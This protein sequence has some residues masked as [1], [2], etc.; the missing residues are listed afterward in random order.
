LKY[1]HNL[2]PLKAELNPACH[3]L[4]LLG[5]HNILHISRIRVNMEF[6]ICGDYNINFLKNSIFKQQI[7]IFF[8]TYNLFQSINFQTRFGKVSIFAVDNIFVDH[9]RIN[10]HHVP[11]HGLSDHE[12]QYLVLSNAY[13]HHKNEKQS[14]R[15]GLIYKEAITYFYSMLINKNWD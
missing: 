12:A 4:A 5:A 6:V 14:F 1:L 8:Q 15:T 13:N 9:G 11:P 2:N 10:S 7:I 3:L